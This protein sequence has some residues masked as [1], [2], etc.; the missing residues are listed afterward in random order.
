MWLVLSLACSSPNQT[1]ENSSN[2]SAANLNSNVPVNSS[3]PANKIPEKE[4]PKDP[5]QVC[6]WLPGFTPG[7]YKSAT[8]EVYECKTEKTEQLGGG[9]YFAWR[10]S[11]LGKPAG[12]RYVEL[13]LTGNN[14]A[15]I[16]LKAEKRFVETAETLWQK[17]FAA[18]LPNEIKD[19]L[20]KNKGK[21]A[22]SVKLFHEPVTAEIIHSVTGNGLYGLSIKFYFFK[23]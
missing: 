17:A 22:E 7:E 4:T 10:Y 2:I 11:A 19:E 15:A 13:F 12:V 9:K 14:N 18:P 6:A 3:V 21:A 23:L 20:L 5:K 1:G 8:P 16:N